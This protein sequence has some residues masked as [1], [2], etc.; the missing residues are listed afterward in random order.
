MSNIRT[1]ATVSFFFLSSSFALKET[2][3][4]QQEVLG[5]PEVDPASLQHLFSQTDMETHVA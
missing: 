5:D 2:S 1:T 3:H 4:N